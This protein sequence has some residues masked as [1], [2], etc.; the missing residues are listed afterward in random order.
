MGQIG[1]W[2]ASLSLGKQLLLGAAAAIA[3]WLLWGM[4][5]IRAFAWYWSTFFP[6]VDLQQFGQ[7]GDLFGGI[8]ALFAA[9]AF[10]GVAIAAYYQHRTW[11]LQTSEEARNREAH[12]QQAFEPLFFKL[13]DRVKRPERLLIAAAVERQMKASWGGSHVSFSAAVDILRQAMATTTEYARAIEK[14]NATV[15]NAVVDLYRATYQTNQAALGPYFRSLYHVFKLISNSTLEP[16]KQVA[17]AN[18]AR[19]ALDA[20]ELFLLSLNCATDEGA[21]FKPLVEE[22]GLLKHIARGTERA[23]IV[24]DTLAVLL[25]RPSAFQSHAERLADRS[26]S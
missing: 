17:Y 1:K 14:S 4:A 13:L 22:Y 9:F 5:L 3:L 24:D 12:A 2:W 6:A 10:V 19:A 18:I 16:E 11:E 20:D 23:P 25:Y 7:L 15:A 8:N 21:K 26:R